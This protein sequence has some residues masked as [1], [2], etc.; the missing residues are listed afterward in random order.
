V[1]KDDLGWVDDEPGSIWDCECLMGVVF[2]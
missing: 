1:D 2:R